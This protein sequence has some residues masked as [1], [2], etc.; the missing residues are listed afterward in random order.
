MEKMKCSLCGKI[1][2]ATPL[3]MDDAFFSR[4]VAVMRALRLAKSTGSVGVCESCMPEYEKLNTA[5]QNKVINYT[6]VAAV[7]GALYF[8]LTSNALMSMLIALAVL[9]LSLFSYCPPLKK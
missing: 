5:F 4:Y 6:I 3:D 9:S 2:K 8:Y 1:G 7:I